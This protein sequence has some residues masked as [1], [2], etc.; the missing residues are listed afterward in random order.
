LAGVGTI[1]EPS[2][3]DGALRQ[4]EIVTGFIQ[5]WVAFDSIVS[6]RD[7]EIESQV[8][9]WVVVVSQDCDLDQDHQSRQ[10]GSKQLKLIPNILFCEV[11]AAQTLRDRRRESADPEEASKKGITSEM[12]GRISLNKDERYH[13]LQKVSAEEDRLGQ[14]LPELA[15]DFKRY[16]TVRT[17][18][19]YHRLRTGAERRC[20]LQSPY[21]EHLSSRF[22]YYLSRVALPGDHFS[23]RADLS[24]SATR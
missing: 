9:P 4:G 23:E 7:P 5:A 14:G 15:I 3:I 18:E 22:C 10:P 17:E 6:G 2:V 19:V 11:I 8:H 13:F 1:Y 20:R 24:A 12:W 21:V 16:F